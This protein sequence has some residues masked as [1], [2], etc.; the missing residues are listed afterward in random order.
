M[1]TSLNIKKLALTWQIVDH[2]ADKE[3]SIMH[4]HHNFYILNYIIMCTAASVFIEG[5]MRP[6]GRKLCTPGLNSKV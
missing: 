1:A 6:Y 5:N 4:R 3:F 2:A